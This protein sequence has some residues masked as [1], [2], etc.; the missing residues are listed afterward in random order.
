MR[1]CDHLLMKQN[2]HSSLKCDGG[3]EVG[4]DDPNTGGLLW[5]WGVMVGLSHGE[6]GG[7]TV[8]E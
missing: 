7:T 3:R 4:T 8:T 5:E 6:K 2:S 1:F